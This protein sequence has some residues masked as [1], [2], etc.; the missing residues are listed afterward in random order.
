MEF[1][2]FLEKAEGDVPGTFWTF[3]WKIIKDTPRVDF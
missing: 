3:L 2:S 1:L